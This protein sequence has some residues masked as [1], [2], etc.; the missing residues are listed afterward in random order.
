MLVGHG[1]VV[2]ALAALGQAADYA[3]VT[4]AEPAAI[5]GLELD[6][7]ASVVVATH[8]DADEDAL[9]RVLASDAGHV[10]LVASRRRAAAIVE[11]LR[12]RG[13]A[14]ER[15]GALRA[16]AGLDIGA[17]TPAEIAVSILAEIIQHGRAE[18]PA[19]IVAAPAEAV[20]PIC[21]MTV[22]VAR[23]RYRTESASGT[24]YFCCRG[25]QEAFESRR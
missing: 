22:D 9:A 7:R 12:A 2:D 10:S 4:V 8:A 17:E 21:G 5:A 23:A 3:V 19:V 14:P 15:L 20:D 6:H 24:V 18:K 13:V 16:P 25:C 11:R 1:P